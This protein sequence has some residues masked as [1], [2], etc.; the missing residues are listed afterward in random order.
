MLSTLGRGLCGKTKPISH[1]QQSGWA[2]MV[3]RLSLGC[4]NIV[5]SFLHLGQS[6]RL[7][8]GSLA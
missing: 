8:L 4:L 1:E 2:L 3:K 7:S 5:P 6:R